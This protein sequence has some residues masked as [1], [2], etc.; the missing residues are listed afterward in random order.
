MPTGYSILDNRPLD[1]WKVT[2]LK[3]ELR[4]RK[5][6]TKGLK[7]DLIKR[8]DEAI[9]TERATVNDQEVSKH[10]EILVTHQSEGVGTEKDSFEAVE[11][12][13]GNKSEHHPIM[14][15]I[16]APIDDP[17]L[18]NEV[19]QEESTTV[20]L[21]E[22]PKEKTTNIAAGKELNDAAALENK[23]SEVSPGLGLQVMRSAPIY[24]DS[25]PLGEQIEP[26]NDSSVNN[27]DLEETV[28]S[29][30]TPS[31]NFDLEEP[32][33]S[34]LIQPSPKP[35]DINESFV[36]ED[37]NKKIDGSL[38]GSP[39]KLNLDRSSSDES[40]EEDVLDTKH[41]ES[42][43]N[44]V[45]VGDKEVR[46]LHVIKEEALAVSDDKIHVSASTE[47]RK[48]EGNLSCGI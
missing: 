47:K 6:T 15:D 11:E 38:G 24:N 19:H 33:K 13:G 7:E 16:N 32:V 36:E 30:L 25:V 44:S 4:R 1:H 8:L 3:D 10:Q 27:F 20:D 48:P 12:F 31:S 39:E 22:G 43:D 46:D 14:V 45:E 18:E 29:E 28:K 34:E 26:K 17:D 23:V 35:L 9:R 40:M 41:V 42:N 37:D 2:E 21:D 5:M